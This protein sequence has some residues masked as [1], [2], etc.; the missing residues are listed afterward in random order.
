MELSSS[1]KITVLLNLLDRQTDDMQRKGEKAQK[2]FEWAASL[3]LASFGVIVALSGRSS[4]LPYPILVK[5]LATILIV[6]PIIL[7]IFRILAQARGAASNAKAVERIEQLLQ[8]FDDGVYGSRSPYPQTWA[9]DY[10][11]KLI[12][13]RRTP[14]AHIL[15]LG[16]MT[17]CVVATIWLIL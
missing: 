3:L 17:A 9:G 6:V 16:L 10:L 2:W 8:L 11:A 12:L 5:L 13:K 7:V 15:I 4:P 1:D 14:I